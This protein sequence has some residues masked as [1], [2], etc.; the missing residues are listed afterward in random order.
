MFS[1]ILV[2][3]TCSYLKPLKKLRLTTLS[4][5]ILNNSKLHYALKIL[6]LFKLTTKISI[7]YFLNI[8]K[9][10]SKNL[11]KTATKKEKIC[12]LDRQ[13]FLNIY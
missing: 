8:R 7:G 5:K 6:L 12:F 9:A 3:D 13:V 10:L 4:L 2:C 11:S 1:W